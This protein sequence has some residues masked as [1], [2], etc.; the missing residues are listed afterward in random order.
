MQLCSCVV[1]IYNA[2]V[3]TCDRRIGFRLTYTGSHNRTDFFSDLTQ[4]N[5]PLATFPS[6]LED[7]LER[8]P[9][10]RFNFRL[11]IF[12]SVTLDLFAKC[13]FYLKLCMHQPTWENFPPE[14]ANFAAKIKEIGEIA[15]FLRQFRQNKQIFQSILT[16]SPAK[17]VEIVKF[18][19]LANFSRQNELN[20]RNWQIFPPKLRKFSNLPA[21]MN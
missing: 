15:K 5:S 2:G 18:T 14:L 1:K 4:Q 3:V 19:K 10:C 11:S 7:R 12:L 21:K 8:G 13:S 16:H 9:F 6:K 20:L 17:I